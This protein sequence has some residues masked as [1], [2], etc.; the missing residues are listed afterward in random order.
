MN[1]KT[2]MGI[3]KNVLSREVAKIDFNNGDIEQLSK[4]IQDFVESFF[5]E[6]FKGIIDYFDFNKNKIK[7]L[8][9]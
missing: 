6:K 5:K 4:D 3:R 1:H 7:N 2:S 9:K 8:L